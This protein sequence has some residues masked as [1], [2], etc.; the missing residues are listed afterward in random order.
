MEYIG[1]GMVVL[2]LVWIGGFAWAH[3][4]A[5]NKAKAAESWPSVPGRVISCE[6]REEESSDREGNTSTW[7]NPVVT[8]AYST[9]GRELQGNRLRFGNPRSGSRRKAEEA[10]LPYGV[11]T[12]P[13]VRYNPERPDE[14]VLETR[15]PGPIYLVMAVFGLL[16]VAMG[17]FWDQMA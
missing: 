11:G 7:Y 13:A 1:I 8:Y 10:I 12:T 16:F 3:F 15:K 4:R 6:V 5:I 14:C 2:G 17:L 9:G